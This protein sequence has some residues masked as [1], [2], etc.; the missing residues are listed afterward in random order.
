CPSVT[1]NDTKRN[2]LESSAWRLRMNQE[3]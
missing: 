1:G 2:R 3:S